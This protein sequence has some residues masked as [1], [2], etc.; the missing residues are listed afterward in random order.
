MAMWHLGTMGFGY[1]AWSGGVFYPAGVKSSEYLA[2]YARHFDCVELDTTFYAAPDEK[3]VRH[4]AAQV[5]ERFRFSVK[6]P[7]EVTH[8]HALSLD[9]AVAPMRA[10]LDVIRA[11]DEK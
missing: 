8:D 6:T 11:F 3:R 2:Y 9:R 1:D 7:R 10:F 4:W 5:P